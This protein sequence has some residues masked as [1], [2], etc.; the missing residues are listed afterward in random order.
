MAAVQI[1]SGGVIF[2][3]V[4]NRGEVSFLLG[5]ECYEPGWRESEKWGGFGGKIEKQ[6]S[7]IGGIAREAY[8]ETCGV[9]FGIGEL[10]QKLEAED[11]RLAIHLLYKKTRFLCY[12]VQV[13]FQPYPK[14]FRATREFVQYA[15]GNIDCV[16]KSQLQWFAADELEQWI[17]GRAHSAHLVQPSA[18]SAQPLTQSLTQS[19]FSTR[20][21]HFRHKFQDLMRFFFTINGVAMLT[22]RQQVPT[23]PLHFFHTVGSQHTT[24]ARAFVPPNENCQPQRK[25]N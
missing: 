15:R 4:N 18:Q 25:E 2:Y 8:E 19:L 10:R 1:K 24:I 3:S 23:T 16:E 7:T 22:R 21:P 5:K 9:I 17:Y 12:F 13:P 11:Y 6:E 14:I 20:R